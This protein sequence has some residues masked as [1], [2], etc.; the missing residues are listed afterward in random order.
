MMLFLKNL[1]FTLVVPGT[2]AV[3]GPLLISADPARATYLTVAF[4]IPFF[5]LGGVLY[6]WCVWNFAQFGRGTPMPLDAPKK[7]VVR[8]LYRYTRNPMYL[9]ALTTILGWAI[10]FQSLPL[11]IYA[12]CAGTLF[13]SF[14]VLYEERHLQKIF[15]QPYTDYCNTVGRWIP[16]FRGKAA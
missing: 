7:L 1:L 12:L 9:C 13:Q 6:A 16:R 11:V 2:V 5:C 8:G 10:A 15:G 3:Y 14:V 4:S